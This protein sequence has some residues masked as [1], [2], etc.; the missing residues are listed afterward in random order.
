MLFGADLN[1][2]Q[3][4]TDS[5]GVERMETLTKCVPSTTVYQVN[6]LKYGNLARFA[7]HCCG[8]GN[9]WCIHLRTGEHV[10]VGMFANETIKKGEEIKYNYAG[11]G[12]SYLAEQRSFFQV[13]TCRCDH[14]NCMSKTARIDAPAEHVSVETSLRPGDTQ[15]R[16]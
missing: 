8:G 12:A 1:C 6:A 7:A 13:G 2:Q 3:M 9:S 10:V 11:E 16:R 14:E 4:V 15:L 5:A